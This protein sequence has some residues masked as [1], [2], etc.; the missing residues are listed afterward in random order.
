MTGIIPVNG[1]PLV[2][3]VESRK[4]GGTHLCDLTDFNGNGS[5]TCGDWSCRC[6][7]NMKGPHELMTDAT[8][9]WHLRRAHLANLQ[10]QV[11]LALAQ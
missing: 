1:R 4:G 11:E 5:C 6:V 8:L 3:L 10:V 7:S 2:Y 9:C